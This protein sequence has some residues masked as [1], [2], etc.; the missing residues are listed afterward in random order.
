MID[1]RFKLEQNILSCWNIV[2]DIDVLT[3]MIEQNTTQQNFNPQIFNFLVGLRTIY[4]VKFNELF[5]TFENLV[6]SKEI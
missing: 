1:D 6:C 3:R 4:D 2:D 5:A